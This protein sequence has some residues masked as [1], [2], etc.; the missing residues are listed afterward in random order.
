MPR[1]SSLTNLRLLP[2]L[3]SKDNSTAASSSSTSSETVVGSPPR[4]GFFKS[5]MKPNANG[6]RSCSLGEKPNIHTNGLMR[7]RRSSSLG[8]N[9]VGSCE[10]LVKLGQGGGSKFKPRQQHPMM[11]TN[12]RQ[13]ST[14][15]VAADA[16]DDGIEQA[17]SKS[18]LDE[19]I[20][21]VESVASRMKTKQ[22][23]DVARE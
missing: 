22:W 10:N 3:T 17:S 5:L 2:F 11:I 15:M 21:G 8:N 14:Q 16:N 13:E 19:L 4:P 7:R 9:Q 1:A 20:V 18:E 6:R 23:E 12:D